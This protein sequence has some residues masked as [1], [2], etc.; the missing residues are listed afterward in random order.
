MGMK[1]PFILSKAM[2]YESHKYAFYWT[3]MNYGGHN[4][5]MMS[6]EHIMRQSFH[7]IQ[8]TGIDICGMIS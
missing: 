6:I 4:N 2:S 5:M 8:M 1:L 7:G 3:G